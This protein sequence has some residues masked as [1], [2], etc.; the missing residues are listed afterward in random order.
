V[1][2]TQSSSVGLAASFTGAGAHNITAQLGVTN[3]S[4]ATNGQVFRVIV[5]AVTNTYQ[6]T[7]TPW[8]SN[9]VYSSWTTN[10]GITIT[11]TANET[12]GSICQ[13]VRNSVTNIFTWTNAAFGPLDLQSNN[14]IGVSISNLVLKLSAYY[15]V[16]P[17]SSNSL[18]I[19]GY[20][21]DWKLLAYTAEWA[22]NW[23]TAVAATTNFVATNSYQV[24]VTNSAA[25]AAT[26]IYTKL[27]ADFSTNMVVSLLNSV[28]IQMITIANPGLA[29]EAT[30]A[31]A[32]NLMTTNAET[33][34]LYFNASHSTDRQLWFADAARSFTV[35]LNGTSAVTQDTN[36][37]SLPPFGWWKWTVENAGT[38][39][40]SALDLNVRT[41]TR[42]GL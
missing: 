25:A 15:D 41:S 18:L 1:D 30:G 22:T 27:A 33:G 8:L 13:I 40:G 34:L 31:W 7:N 37:S 3:S 42:R 32:T 6:W 2:L 11:N 39:Y 38:N 28:A 19:T 26:N 24:M 29:I 10:L 12:N 17:Q 21:T 35:A 4:K 14:D 20:S 36:Y 23:N 5:G 16:L 9:V